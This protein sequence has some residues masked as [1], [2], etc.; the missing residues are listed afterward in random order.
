M[1]IEA[2]CQQMYETVGGRDRTIAGLADEL[3]AASDSELD[4]RIRVLELMRRRL[5]AE[6]ALTVAVAEQRQTF[7]ADGHRGM[8]GYLRATCNWSNPEIAARRR[9]GSAADA[10]PGLADA[11][12]AGHIG[13][14]QAA[15]IARVHRNP[16]VRDRLIEFAPTLL[17]LAE[18]HSFDDFMIALQRFEMLADADGAH[19]HRDEQL[20]RRNVHVT[21]VGGE[22]HLDATGGDPLVNDELEAI[23]RRFC[24]HEFRKDAA[25]RRDEHGD[26]AAGKPLARTHTQRSYDAFVE[27][28]R[29][30]NTSLDSVADAPRAP[31]PL[32]N[33]VV[34]HRTWGLVL[35][36]AD[37]TPTADLW[38]EPVDPFTGLP[39][40]T[41]GDLLADLVADPSAFANLRCETSNGTPLHP[42]DVLRATLAGHVRRVIV[43]ALGVPIDLGRK[44]RLFEGP[45][46]EAA[47]LLVRHCDHRGCDLPADF[48]EVDH[49]QE[50]TD[51]GTTDQANAGI[52]CGHHNRHKHK[53]RSTSRLD[54][55]GQRQTIRPDGTIVLPVGVRPPV[56][57]DEKSD[58]DGAT[59][60]GGLDGYQFNVIPFRAALRAA[61]VIREARARIERLTRSA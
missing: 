21:T 25:V 58:D 5:D 40:T 14:A 28:M 37:L 34:D 50:W 1:D 38:G 46:R 41:S 49:V 57:P 11:L 54:I 33:V 12:H 43:D 59:A 23:F 61:D 6:L 3:V 10:V 2:L 48:C 51:D 22:L 35:A 27:L 32:V 15:A 17:E 36:A 30:A 8:P 44:R 45:A 31:D 26:D 29:R 7:L 42:H 52:A 56:F 19:A 47:K 60:S 55:F 13:V 24:E 20:D 18:R 53:H 16:R 39:A 4:V 9:L